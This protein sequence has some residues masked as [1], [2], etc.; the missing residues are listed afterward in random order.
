MEEAGQNGYVAIGEGVAR[1][2]SPLARH[3]FNG[4]IFWKFD[5]RLEFA[6]KY[7]QIIFHGTLKLRKMFLVFLF[8]EKGARKIP[9]CRK[10]FWKFQTWCGEK[11]IRCKENVETRRKQIWDKYQFTF[12]KGSSFKVW[13]ARL[14]PIILTIR[15]LVLENWTRPNS[16][17]SA[18]PSFPYSFF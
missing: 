8:K 12:G 10:Q 11:Q 2:V 9:A 15:R 18:T 7:V 6:R 16:W 1:W 5:A 14:F 3:L 13:R 17:P 4:Q